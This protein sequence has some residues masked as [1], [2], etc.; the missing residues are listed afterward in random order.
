MVM[1]VNTTSAPLSRVLLIPLRALPGG[2]AA[3]REHAAAAAAAVTAVHP[4]RRLGA[5]LKKQPVNKVKD[6]L[7]SEKC[8]QAQIQPP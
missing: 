4:T 3:G 8:L 2:R 7:E 6:L 1:Q 5:V